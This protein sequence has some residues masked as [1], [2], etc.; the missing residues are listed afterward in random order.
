MRIG[1]SSFPAIRRATWRSGQT[2][3]CTSAPATVRASTSSIT[4]S[5]AARPGLRPPR[6]RTRAPI[7][8]W[9]AVPCGARTC[10]PNQSSG[11]VSLRGCRRP[12]RPDRLVPDGRAVGS[13]RRPDRRIERDSVRRRHPRCSRPNRRLGRRRDRLQRNER[14][15]VCASPGQAVARERALEHRALGTPRL[16]RRQLPIAGRQGPGLAER[17]LRRRVQQVPILEKSNVDVVTPR[18]GFD[19]RLELASLGRHPLRRRVDH[20][21]LQGWRRRYQHRRRFP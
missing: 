10:A 20:A 14:L 15:R 16:D 9:K 21:D 4:G 6:R 5:S 12:G 19:D 2:A 1:A 17:V 18:D 8:R 3:P 7:R 13:G 11:G